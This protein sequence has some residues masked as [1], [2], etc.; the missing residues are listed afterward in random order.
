MTE[1]PSAGVLCFSLVASPFVRDV[2]AQTMEMP[3]QTLWI[4]FF[5]SLD[6]SDR[7][8]RLPV[9]IRFL[10][11][12]FVASCLLA[13]TA[14][15]Q[16]NPITST[17]RLWLEWNV[18]P[19][20]QWAPGPVDSKAEP[21]RTLNVFKLQPV[22]PFRLNDEWTLLT[23]TIFR[24]VSAPTAS[25]EVGLTPLGELALLGW[26]QTYGSGLS[27]VSPTAFFVPNLGPHWTIGLGPSLV[28]PVGDLPTNSGKLSLG[29]AVLG[30][31]H[32][33]PWTVGARI[34]N[35]WSVAG[36]PQRDD[37]N[38]F[39]AQPLIRY[40]LS[41]NLYFTSSPIISSDLTHPDGDGWTVPV[42][43]G[44]GYTFRLANQPTQISLE[45]YFNAVKQKVA[46]EELLGDW[47]IRT[48]WQV[49]FPK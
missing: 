46:G 3:L 14:A 27:D 24:F 32:Q 19:N 49:L 37:V 2:L 33:G 21:D 10:L 40:Q 28:I 17:T 48:Q 39:I 8:M 47:T 9:V 20:V 38:R 35:I 26:D 31:Y 18:S 29:P 6:C 11:G 16:S 12:G 1:L 4:G 22:A 44:L 34:R 30:Y 13:K 42:G 43:G 36:D 25:P 7:D 45:A 41:K 5:G 15:A 23:R